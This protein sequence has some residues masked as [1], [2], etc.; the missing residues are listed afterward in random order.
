M[1]NIGIF[2][3]IVVLNSIIAGAVLG[4]FIGKMDVIHNCETL[5]VFSDGDIVYKCYKEEQSK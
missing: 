4:K 1:M 5:K 3:F 2:I